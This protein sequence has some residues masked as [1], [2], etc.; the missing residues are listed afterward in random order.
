VIANGSNPSLKIK[1]NSVSFSGSTITINGSGLSDLTYVKYK[2]S[3][4]VTTTLDILTK[5][6]NQVTFS[7]LSAIDLIPGKVFNFILG[8]A[9]AQALIEVTLAIPD[10]S[11]TLS[12]M[13]GILAGQGVLNGQVL[14]W[15]GST[16][17]PADL[18]VISLTG[19]LVP[20]V[21]CGNSFI[22]PNTL[23]GIVTSY[24]PIP[25]STDARGSV[26]W[27]TTTPVAC[28]ITFGVG[29]GAFSSAPFCVVSN[30]G[31]TEIPSTV[32]NIYSTS[33]TNL[34]ITITITN[35][36]A[37]TGFSWMCTQ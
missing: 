9:E 17:A 27:D 5:A 35:G 19:T 6:E 3:L 21:S 7:L 18:R 31:V 13:N 4:G 1:A 29:T 26:L 22:A 20:T 12:K 25:D 24:I 8:S 23:S 34:T 36:V 10:N 2:S 15:N 11:I 28:S 32:I 14:Q 16:W 30:F 37:S 33:L